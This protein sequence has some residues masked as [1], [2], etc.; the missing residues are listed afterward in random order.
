VIGY[1]YCRSRFKAWDLHDL[2]LSSLARPLPAYNSGPLLFRSSPLRSP[3]LPAALP[4]PLRF[5]TWPRDALEA[6]AFKFLR[7]ME[8]DEATRTHLVQLCQAF[9]SKIRSASEDFRVQLGRYNYVTPT[10]YLELI[11]TFRCGAELLSFS[12]FPRP[13]DCP[14]PQSSVAPRPRQ[15]ST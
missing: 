7:E 5:R 3:L 2:R 14:L 8:L 12:A 10:S 11:N 13:K 15:Q 4:A 6:V 1:V 9:H